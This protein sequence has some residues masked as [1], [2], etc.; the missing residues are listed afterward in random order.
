MKKLLP[1]LLV[2]FFL[3]TNKSYA[4]LTS[5]QVMDSTVS[6]SSE[7]NL[8]V[9]FNVGTVDDVN[10]VISINWGDGD[11]EIIDNLTFS[12]DGSTTNWMTLSHQYASFGNYNFEMSAVSSVNG[13][14][15][16]S[17]PITL[18][19]SDYTYC[20]SVYGGC[21]LETDCGIFYN[22][23]INNVVYDLIGNDNTV[24][25][26]TDYLAGVNV[27]NVPY[28]LSVNDAWLQANNLTQTSAD[29]TITG[30]DD[31]GYPIFSNLNQNNTLSVTS[32]LNTNEL[33]LS[34]YWGYGYGILPLENAKVYFQII[35]PTCYQNP[36]VQ[37]S[38]TYPSCLTP[39][40]TGLSNA[41]ISGNTLTY[42]LL[43]FQYE[44]Q[45]ILFS[46][47]PATPLETILDFTVTVSDLDGIETIVN[48]NSLNFSGIVYNS[49]DPNSKLV[50]KP[51]VLN[52]DQTEELQYIINFQNEGNYDAVNIEV[53]DTIA[54]NLDLSTFKVLST[55]H[56]VATSVDPTTRIVKFKFDN[57]NLPPVSQDE[58]GSKG[59]IV[60]SI[61][62]NEGLP[63]NSEI[64]NTAYIYFDFNEA[65]V[66]NTT[67]NKNMLVGIH[68]N[69][70]SIF[71]LFP[72][73]ASDNF[74]VK[75]ENIESVSIV[76]ATGKM[77]LSLPDYN[78][79]SISVS[80]LKNGVY[81]VKIRSN[82]TIITEKISIQK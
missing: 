24:T 26:F 6:C 65:I 22:N 61:K 64:K 79:E 13:Q 54:E 9:F 49:Y 62:E 14:T 32:T 4:Q 23:Y 47:D 25:T 69:Q 37:V 7:K 72:N 5:I 81:F 74:M 19:Y 21:I 53:V 56:S 20:G 52:P 18:V 28:T 76:D 1:F 35:N 3:T 33:D 82:H 48:N 80:D 78:H 42:D 34:V 45:E 36:N 29:L 2:G 73:P 8:Q 16:S 44:L 38:L 60:Y 46:L 12:S 63:L 15:V 27:T 57:I 11:T 71:K 77:I 68:E 70:T 58:E 51:Y 10:P 59:K 17:S 67:I 43:N 50:N 55:V 39:D 41:S 30:F 75:G 31:F 40:L 66:T